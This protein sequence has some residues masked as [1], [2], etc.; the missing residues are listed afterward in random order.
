M[1]A[2]AVAFN[3]KSKM[4]FENTLNQAIYE[5]WRS[6]YLDYNGLKQLVYFDNDD[7]AV[8]RFTAEL[9]AQLEKIHTFQSDKHDDLQSRATECNKTLKKILGDKENETDGIVGG[10]GGS[11]SA[12]GGGDGIGGGGGGGGGNLGAKTQLWK[13][14]DAITDELN[15][16]EAYSRYNYTGLMKIV[17]KF[18]KMHPQYRIKPMLN[19]RLAKLPFNNQSYAALL[20]SLSLMYAQLRHHPTAGDDAATNDLVPSGAG[21]KTFQTVHKYWIHPDNI[22]EV[23]TR[24][25]RR[26]P[27][28]VYTNV[29]AQKDISPTPD[30]IISNLYFDNSKFQLYEEN[31]QAAVPTST[32]RIRWFGQLEDSDEVF[33]EQHYVNPAEAID[34]VE[35]RLTIKKKYVEAFLNGT[36]RMEKTIKRMQDSGK[37]EAEISAFEKQVA[38][39]Q[40]LIKDRSLEPMLRSVYKRTSFQIPGDNSV[41]VNI[42]T[43]IALIREDSLDSE[44]P[45]RNPDE[46]HRRD[47]DEKRLSYPFSL[48]RKGEINK[49]PFG[50]M[51]IRLQHNDL[52]DHSLGPDWVVELMKSHLVFEASQF[53]KYANGVAVLDEAY[54]NMYPYWLSKLDSEIRRNPDS[55][56]EDNFKKTKGES[57]KGGNKKGD[58]LPS[59]GKLIV[60]SAYLKGLDKAVVP[61]GASSSIDT[62]NQTPMTA[63]EFLSPHDF[64]DR[65]RAKRKD[66]IAKVVDLGDSSDENS[67]LLGNGK[68]TGGKSEKSRLSTARLA[69]LFS[70]SRTSQKV[71]L[72]PGVS[73]PTKLLKNAGPVKVEAKVWLAN[74][75]TFIKW[76]HV[77]SLLSFLSLSL[78]NG[79]GKDNDVGRRLGFVYTMI[80]VFAALWGL[81]IYRKRAWQI[82]QR[83]GTPMNERFGPIV[84]TIA[85]MSALLLNFN[86]KVCF[87]MYTYIYLFIL[88]NTN[89]LIRSI[90][91]ILEQNLFLNTHYLETFTLL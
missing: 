27:V 41:R 65:S 12:G 60:G 22:M 47:I 57:R 38:T 55:E 62:K 17:K 2:A 73:K 3:C 77:A 45:V 71:I 52:Y 80:A 16:L 21:E 14:L 91:S 90:K 11:S 68:S 25:L 66:K 83:S 26:L 67:E 32:L 40:N 59:V 53:S 13:E 46:W 56:E 49:F 18:D 30:P 48:L 58:V 74:E 79:A 4:H 75:R 35:A 10:G 50:Y 15:Q 33:I 5:P 61:L 9:N 6:A 8:G 43:D 44:R 23:K 78:Y 39:I 69:S 28:L 85:L 42:D 86:F 31:L 89:K 19:A 88:D 82:K 20:Q 1:G 76:L 51:E 54:V 64:S 7:E 63:R 84:V 24:I 37:S 29:S 87:F 70:N 36:Y 72:P 34:N 81:F